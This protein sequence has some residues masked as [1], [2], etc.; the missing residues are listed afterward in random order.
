[1][2]PNDPNALDSLGDLNLLQGHLREAE[3]LYLQA[4]KKNPNFLA[5][6]PGG[7]LFKAAIARAMTGDIAGADG[8]QKQFIQARSAVHDSNVP[9]QEV[10]WLWLTGRRKPAYDQLQTLASNAERSSQAPVAIRAYAEL[11]L[12]SLMNQDRNTAAAMAQKAI[13]LSTPAT[14]APAVI[15]Q[16]LAQPSVSGEEWAA[17]AERFVSKPEQSAF[18]DQMLAYALLLDGKVSAAAPPLQRTYDT[19]GVGQNEGLAVL[20]AWADLASGNTGAAAELLKLNP[21]PPPTGIGT[22]MPL[23]LPRIFELRS[24]VAA[25]AGRTEAANKNSDLFQKFR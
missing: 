16:F 19:T 22:F 4:N 25:K 9:F 12:W 23:Y 5:S 15:S 8:L 1:L 7:D 20:L 18:K 24:Q 6:G 13:T 17:R 2:R 21:I 3:D 10:E 14:A 11:A